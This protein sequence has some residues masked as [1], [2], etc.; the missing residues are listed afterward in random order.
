MTKYNYYKFI[1]FLGTQFKG[2]I[3]HGLKIQRYD[4]IAIYVKYLFLST[5]LL[6][7]YLFI[8]LEEVV[9][10]LQNMSLKNALIL[11]LNIPKIL[12]KERVLEKD[13][14]FLIRN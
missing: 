8:F 4:Q 1:T 14:G 9:Y 12:I 11:E 6:F 5:K 7:I 3:I 10:I 2:I 13:G